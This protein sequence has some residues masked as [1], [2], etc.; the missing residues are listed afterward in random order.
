MP[1]IATLRIP[2]FSSLSAKNRLHMDYMHYYY[3]GL[4][5]NRFEQMFIKHTSE[6]DIDKCARTQ[7]VPDPSYF[8]HFFF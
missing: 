4:I 2:F 1:F 8:T 3:K 6:P 5:L 7:E